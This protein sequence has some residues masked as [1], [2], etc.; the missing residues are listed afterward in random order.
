MLEDMPAR[1]ETSRARS[2]LARIT[3]PVAVQFVKF[4]IVGVSN[5]LL[6]FLVYTLLLKV[7]DVWY[8]AASA[9]GFIVG[10]TNSFLLNRKWTF[11]EHVG[12]SMTPVRWAIVQGCGLGLNL[13]LLALFVREAG[14]DELIA[15]AFATVIVTVSTFFAN[16]TWTFPVHGP[17]V[18]P[19]PADTAMQSP[20]GTPEPPVAG[21]AKRL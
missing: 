12:D 18:A 20:A 5:T 9:I 10:T 6:T 4:G 7:F 13:G 2:L 3:H 15:Q 1:S 14:L 11:S 8:I 17:P 19:P 21:S 16:R